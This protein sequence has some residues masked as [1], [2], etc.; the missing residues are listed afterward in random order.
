MRRKGPSRPLRDLHE[1]GYLRGLGTVLD[2]GCGHGADVAYLQD[3]SIPARGYDPNWKPDPERSVL[4]RK[5]NVVLSTYVLNVLVGIEERLDFYAELRRLVSDKG[6]VYLTFRTDIK[7]S[8]TQF[9][10]RAEDF[11]HMDQYFQVRYLWSGSGFK[12]YALKPR[13]R[14]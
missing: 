9:P 5:F 2:H 1:T 11:E 6:T 8:T 12:T 14:Q 7:T 10:I 3:E 4:G 13:R